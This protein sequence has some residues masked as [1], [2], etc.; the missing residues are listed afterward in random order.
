M[1]NKEEVKAAIVTGPKIGIRSSANF[2]KSSASNGMINY[3]SSNLGVG[4]FG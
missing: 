1:I 3:T 4:G 2:H